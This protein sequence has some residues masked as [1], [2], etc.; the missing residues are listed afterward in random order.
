MKNKLLLLV[1][2]FVSLLVSS[3]LFS[4]E[5]PQIETLK[6]GGFNQSAKVN[7]LDAFNAYG[8]DFRSPNDLYLFMDPLSA[9]GSWGLVGEDKTLK[10]MAGAWTGTEWLMYTT[11]KPKSY[12]AP[13]RPGFYLSVEPVSGSIRKIGNGNANKDISPNSMTYD[14]SDR[15]LYGIAGNVFYKMSLVDTTITRID[16]LRLQDGTIIVDGINVISSTSNGVIYA[17]SV[18]N[19]VYRVNKD[20]ARAVLVGNTGTAVGSNKVQ[21]QS[22]CFDYRTNR[23]YWASNNPSVMYEI[24][25]ITGKATIVIPSA[26]YIK[27]TSLFVHYYTKN[28]PPGEPTDMK[29]EKE[30]TNPRKVTITA[31]TPMINFNGETQQGISKAYLYRKVVEL[32]AEYKII[33]SIAI[34]QNGAEIKFI[35]EEPTEGVYMYGIKI[36]DNSYRYN[37]LMVQKKVYCFDMQ[38]PYTTGFESGD[39]NAPITV[40]NAPGWAIVDTN[41]YAGN[42]CYYLYSTSSSRLQFNGIPIKKGASY[43]ISMMLRLGK[44]ESKV[45][46][47]SSYFINGGKD[48]AMPVIQMTGDKYAE[49]QLPLNLAPENGFMSYYIKGIFGKGLFV[50]N[51]KITQTSTEKVPDTAVITEVKPAINGEDA[52][53]VKWRTPSTDASGAALENL[54]GIIIKRC[55]NASF[56]ETSSSYPTFTDTVKTFEQGNIDLAKIFV[57]KAGRWY[58]RVSAYNSYGLSP[59]YTTSTYSEWIG[60]DTIPDSPSNIVATALPDGKIKVKWDSVKNVGLSGGY[61]NG[62]ITGYK[63]IYYDVITVGSPK[64]EATVSE[65]EFTTASL[66]NS[67]YV[68]EIQSIRNNLNLSS[69]MSRAGS[70]AASGNLSVVLNSGNKAGTSS[71]STTMPFLLSEKN[72]IQS[73][74][75]Q[76]L[77]TKE[78]MGGPRVIDTLIYYINVPQYEK[79]P[80]KI[81]MDYKVDTPY[82]VTNEDWVSIKQKTTVLVFND[83]LEFVPGMTRLAIPIKPWFYDG[84]T[85]MLT[86]LI[87]KKCYTSVSKGNVTVYSVEFPEFS[88]GRGDGRAVFQTRKIDD[89]TYTFVDYDTLKDVGDI[90]PYKA[91]MQRIPCLLITEP[92]TL[93]EINGT[94]LSLRTKIP[95][96]AKISVSPLTS[97][98][99]PVDVNYT[100]FN[101]SEDGGKFAFS[102]MIANQYSI[103]V[104]A[105]GYIDS[106][107]TVTIGNNDI[108]TYNICL[109]E[110]QKVTLSGQVKNE[111]GEALASVPLELKGIETYK[112]ET[113]SNG[114]FSFADIYNNTKYVL[115]AKRSPYRDYEK[116]IVVGAE[117]VNLGE[118]IMGYPLAPITYLES[119][120]G[121][122]SVSLLWQKPC[123][124]ITNEQWKQWCN[125]SSFNAFGADGAYIM[126]ACRFTPEDMVSKGIVGKKLKTIRFRLSEYQTNYT[127]RVFQGQNAEKEIYSKNIGPKNMPRWFDVELPG[128][129]EIDYSKDLYIAVEAAVGYTG[130]PIPVDEGPNK[131][132]LRSVV[133]INGSW[134][135]IK[136]LNPTFSFHLSIKALFATPT[137]VDPKDGYNI[138]RMLAEDREEPQK[139]TLINTSKVAQTNYIDNTW[140]TA[141]MGWYQYA[142]KANYGDDLLSTAVISGKMT[143]LLEFD[144]VVN[145]RGGNKNGK[146]YVYMLSKD[147]NIENKRDAYVKF[148]DSVVFEKV[149]RGAYEIGVSYPS[150]E[151]K[152]QT[153]SIISDTSFTFGLSVESISD[154]SIV[155]CSSVG[156]E[157]A[158]LEWTM[159]KE[160]SFYESFEDKEDFAISNLSPYILSAPVNKGGVSNAT[161]KNTDKHQSWIVFNPSKTTPSVETAPLWTPMKGN[162]KYLAAFYAKKQ[163]NDDWFIMPTNS[164]GY[165]SF[166][167][168]GVG[169]IGV[170]ESMQIM[171]SESTS[172]QSSF[173]TL[174]LPFIISKS[175]KQ[176]NYYLPK[177]AKYVAIRYVSNDAMAMM[178]D[179]IKFSTEGQGVP[180]S[181]ELYLDGTKVGVASSNES[182]FLFNKL[183][184]GEH[185]LGV[186]AI[187]KTGESAIVEGIVD[188]TDNEID[189]K[190]EEVKVYPNPSLDGK[191][192]VHLYKDMNLEV[193]ALNGEKL[194]TRRLTTGDNKVDMKSYTG[195]MYFFVFDKIYNVKV[196]K[197]GR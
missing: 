78:E 32:S 161:W 151:S 148:G 12:S 97:G 196:V 173:K 116:E 197:S 194:L 180:Q 24:D 92:N 5:A 129:L 118:V 154:P 81:Y 50:D 85:S 90:L 190:N 7:V 102:K 110:A 119:K 177:A 174:T 147:G 86:T 165:L 175:W 130:F 128:L 40:E 13:E 30:A 163:A 58:F 57:P 44:G 76:T 45:S 191:Y 19:N 195:G 123:V 4:Q 140:K 91:I 72:K 186:K 108:K 22:A 125:D 101:N 29:S 41:V 181:Y 120:K 63:I 70:F 23:M 141:P 109:D 145:V 159:L 21:P 98:Q 99:A 149:W 69:Y 61:L 164:S 20:N 185:K 193:Y 100:F 51:F 66:P 152:Y 166:Y 106:S 2:L 54:S 133:F 184:R 167:A 95:I 112:T 1:T 47:S 179:E 93:G 155:A 9:Y 121:K 115:T 8:F 75:C 28:C 35:V 82:M 105:L 73:S 10:I 52:A 126:G 168:N 139:W 144:V 79:I 71:G 67:A 142:V 169:L 124:A 132:T 42:K 59:Y 188:I 74:I 25:T 88:V 62:A 84:S 16:T 143:K 138:Y 48:M 114:E 31:K 113:G 14:P 171:Y 103:R 11:I 89:P 39:K 37:L 18:K 80:V 17:I 33:D 117:D 137:E 134:Q 156:T 6:F 34:T 189:A 43:K 26:N 150:Y 176:Y 170:F 187:F 158:K 104:S 172:D 77:Y 178:L 87:K 122:D 192:N 96:I 15:G 68:F 135:D 162:K 46:A 36:R 64:K 56:S 111:K 94:V 53:M 65:N 49:Y 160:N 27:T 146:A 127:V 182:A 55:Q 3:S 183:A 157:N 107:F 131:D 153:S 83:S 136:R 60:M 38:L